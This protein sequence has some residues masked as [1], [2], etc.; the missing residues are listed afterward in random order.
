VIF[1]SSKI[2]YPNQ[3]SK[4]GNTRLGLLEFT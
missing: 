3:N 2:K 1:V 4:V